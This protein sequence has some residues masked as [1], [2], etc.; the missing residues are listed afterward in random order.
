MLRGSLQA[1]PDGRVRY[2]LAT[3]LAA[4][5][6]PQEAIQ[7]LLLAAEELA[8]PAPRAGDRRQAAQVRAKLAELF[9]QTGNRTAARRESAYALES[10]PANGRALLILRTLEAE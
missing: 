6:R 2:N 3:V 8:P 7:E 10:D 4:A 9:L 1:R 5:G